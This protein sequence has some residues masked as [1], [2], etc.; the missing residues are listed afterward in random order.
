MNNLKANYNE[1][2]DELK[3]FDLRIIAASKYIDENGIIAAYNLG[4]RDFGEN[5]VQDALKKLNNLPDEIKNNCEWHFIGHLQSNK[6]RKVVAN[7]DYIHS[8][9]SLD[10]AQ[11]VNRVAGE[12]NKIQKVLLEVNISQEKSKWGLSEKEVYDIFEQLLKLPNIKVIGLMGMA[13]NTSNEGLLEKTF[14]HLANLQYNIQHK[15]QVEFKELS[16]GMSGDYKVA[17]KAGST[18]IRLG[19]R[20]FK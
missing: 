10:I 9:D 2:L 13:E 17:A 14:T 19:Q 1:V 3:E 8:I 12:M 5:R 6:V 7:F 16:M 11:T 4:I 20:L 15:Y 18:M